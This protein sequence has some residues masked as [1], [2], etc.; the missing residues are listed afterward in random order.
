VLLIV[1]SAIST[2]DKVIFK[3]RELFKGKNV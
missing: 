2:V 1:V 3:T